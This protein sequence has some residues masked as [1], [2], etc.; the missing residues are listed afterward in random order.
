L[1]A[2]LSKLDEK[3]AK[4]YHE[5]S[6]RSRKRTPPP[7][8]ARREPAR[9]PTTPAGDGQGGA[10]RGGSGSQGLPQGHGSGRR[11]EGGFRAR[12]RRGAR[13]EPEGDRRLKAKS[14]TLDEKA[15]KENDKLA[16][17]LEKDWEATKKAL[18]RAKSATGDA[19]KATRHEVNHG[20]HKV[21]SAAKAA[22]RELKNYETRST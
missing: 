11:R 12:G 16:A 15:R 9:P 2:G 3:T 22:V 10:R 7:R 21:K 6:T 18:G 1:R 8:S 17:A 20:L 5:R 19:W 13:G 14:A 4:V